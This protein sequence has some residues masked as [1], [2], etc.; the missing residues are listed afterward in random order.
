MIDASKNSTLNKWGIRF[1]GKETANAVIQHNPEGGFWLVSEY[2]HKFKSIT[3][4]GKTV[5]EALIQ[6][7]K[8]SLKEKGLRAKEYLYVQV[9]GV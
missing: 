4:E 2:P 7:N 6:F 5:E 9:E 1:V 3:G 8:L